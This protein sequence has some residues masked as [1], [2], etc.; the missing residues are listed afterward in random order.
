MK[1]IFKSI[2]F[3]I[4]W[5]A[6][7][8]LFLAACV[9][10][11]TQFE[12]YKYHEGQRA[13]AQ[14]K[15]DLLKQ[16]AGWTQEDVKKNVAKFDRPD[17]ASLQ[18]YEMTMDPNLGYVP[19]QRRF[20][21]YKETQRRLANKR[22]IQGVTW[23]ERG[24]NNVGGRTRA[25]MFDPNDATSKKV[26]AGGAGGGLWYNTNITS[27]ATQWQAVDNFWAN[28]AISCIAY[29]PSNTQNFYIGTGLGFSGY[30]GG[31]KGEGIWKSSNGGTSWS[32]LTSTANSTFEYVSRIGI[33]SNG[34]ILAATSNGIQRST[35]GGSS[36]TMVRS[37]DAADLKIAANGN[38]YATTGYLSQAGKVYKSTNDG[39]TWTDITPATGAARIELAVAPSNGNVVYAVS[40]KANDIGTVAWLYKSTNGGSSWTSKTIPKYTT[41]S[42]TLDAANDFT[43]GQAFYDLTLVVHPTNS[44]IVVMGGIDIV[45]TTDGGSSWNLMT[46]WTGACSKPYQHADQHTMQFRPGFNNELI[47]GSDGGVAYSTNMG[48]SSAPNMSDRNNGYNVTQFYA[49]DMINTTGSNTMIAGAQD[50]GTHRFTTTGVNSTNMVSGGDGAFCHI[51]Q[52]NG[53]YQISSYVYNSYYRSTDGG[54]NFTSILNVSNRGRFINPTDYDDSANILYASGNPDEFIRVSGITGTI[55]ASA[56]A[57]NTGGRSI[58]AVK[59]SPYT[60]N[61]IFIA[62]D[63]GKVYKVES[64]NGTATISTISTSSLPSGYISCIAVGSSDNQ[65]MVTYTSYGVTS[66][67]ETKNGGSSW[68][69]KEGNLPDMPIRWALY[70]PANT[71]EVLLATELGVW[72]VEDVSVASPVWEVTSAGLAHVRCDMLQYRAADKTVGV[73][74]HGR[75]LFTGSPFSGVVTPPASCTTTVSSFPYTQNF[76]S[77]IGLTQDTGDDLDWTRQTG[78]TP[79]GS[80]GPSAANQGSYYAYIEASSPNYPSKVANLITP[81]LNTAGASTTTLTF[82]YHMYGAAMGTLNVQVQPDGAS[83]WTTVW[84]LSG[85]QTNTWNSATVDLASYAGQTFKIRF[86]GVTGSSYT[87]DISIDDVSVSTAAAATCDVPTGLASSSV[88]QSG[89]TLTW[90][91]MAGATSYD[92]KIGANTYN[93]ASNSYTATGLNASTTYVSSVRTNCASGSSAYSASINTTTSAAPTC[94]VPTGLASSSVSQT[95]FTLTWAAVANATSYDV[96]IG[97]NTYNTSTNSYT[98]TGL[99]ASTTYSSSVRTNC[100][101]GS[102]AYSSAINTTTS[103]APPAGLTC[104]TTISAFPYNEGFEGGFG[105]WSQGSGDDFDWTRKTGATASNNTGPT[106]AAGGSYYLYT[107]ASNPNNPSKTTILNGPCFDLGAAT[108]STLTFKYHMYGAANMGDLKL[109]ASTTDGT[110]TDIWSKTGNQGNAW[111]TATVD[112]AAYLG[113]NVKLRFFGTTGTTWQ[114]DMAIDDLNMTAGSGGGGTTAV[115]LNINFDQYASETT[116]TLK[117]SNGATVDSGSGYANGATN[118]TKN[119]DLPAGCYDFTI[120]DSYGDGICC[121]YGNGDYTLVAA[122]TTVASGGAFGS[123]ETTNFCVGGATATPPP[124]VTEISGGREGVDAEPQYLEEFYTTVY[125]NP[126][127]TNVS[128]VIEGMKNAEYT[129]VDLFGRA[130]LKGEI[131]EGRATIKL[132]NLSKGVY[133]IK[134][135]DGNAVVTKKFIKK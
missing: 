109:Q 122:G 123:G 18:D 48:S 46:Y 27:T 70:N 111:L 105:A 124:T 73:A 13:I 79:S 117:D 85:D 113:G 84:T 80:T 52:D 37:G 2:S 106:S 104:S 20:A 99:S 12:N 63:Q 95:G 87:S 128:I 16:Y 115:T 54:A 56:V 91:A 3:P 41:Q 82:D 55:A 90:A 81:C 121:S 77:G 21:A 4:K 39:S 120:S 38:I 59:V 26:W 28:L 29:D 32:Q 108:S 6:M 43:R 110:W 130:I 65:I 129:V 118:F 97:A 72:S 71:N 50:N 34:T 107:E 93:T 66:V 23:N 51:D 57:V 10:S 8:A 14:Q 7:S 19:N 126:A 5:G 47:V 53:N 33:T 135:D 31:T 36:W 116:W 92:V 1:N 78:G 35:N 86:N 101:S 11:Y 103:A 75:G 119:F 102:S 112:M 30:S 17:L 76:E 133:F 40:S 127:T 64:A 58:S 49:M 125:P 89:F 88:T 96:K 61:R 69:N 98:A 68:Q 62:N 74:T 83:T 44:N 25:L 134:V 67:W 100:A 131:S 132:S 15:L 42:C 9:F 60:A 22:A 45:K 114:G 94:N 24:P